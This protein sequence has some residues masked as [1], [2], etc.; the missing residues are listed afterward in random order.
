M[1]ESCKTG[2][3]FLNLKGADLYYIKSVLTEAGFSNYLIK[4]AVKEIVKGIVFNP[5]YIELYDQLFNNAITIPKYL[6]D[7]EDY[8]YDADDLLEIED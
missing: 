5:Y 6:K 7:N 4:T 3:T 2:T 8:F 1:H